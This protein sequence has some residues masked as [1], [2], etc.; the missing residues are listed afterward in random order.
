MT[1]ADPFDPKP[2]DEEDP[3][4]LDD[5]GDDLDDDATA[6]VAVEYN[7]GQVAHTVHRD[8]IQIT[9][10]TRQMQRFHD[11]H[12]LSPEYVR[13]TMAYF[14]ERA[15][16]TVGNQQL[17]RDSAAELFDV[18]SCIVL[19]GAPHSGLRTAGVALLDALSRRP[20]PPLRLREVTGWN[21]A[22]PGSLTEDA[23]PG[24]RCGYLLTIPADQKAP[25]EKLLDG[26]R[27]ELAC[28]ASFL[29]IVASTETFEG[30]AYH[31]PGS[32]LA[33]SPPDGIALLRAEIRRLGI[34][35]RLGGLANHSEIAALARGATPEQV[36]RLARLM[37]EATGEDD[38][39]AKE[40]VAAYKR[41]N[42]ELIRWFIQHRDIR[43]RAFLVATA[44]AEGSHAT[45]VLSCA[46]HL[47]ATLH[48][49]DRIRDG[50]GDAGIQELAQQ[51]G[52]VVGPD[53][54]L[55]FDKPAYGPAVLDYLRQDRSQQFHE[56]FWEWVS[57]LPIALSSSG[58]LPAPLT[59]RVADVILD[60]ILR[61]RD[62]LILRKV[63]VRWS[64]RQDLRPALVAVLSAAAL[65]PEAGSLTRDRLNR[66]AAKSANIGLLC[67]IAEVC[68]DKLADTY[69]A[70]AFVRLSHLA[71]HRSPVVAECV[72]TA[73]ERLW[74]RPRLRH[75]VLDQL[76]QWLASD[77]GP[78]Y[79]TA[80]EVIRCLNATIDGD[81][82]LFVT[83]QLP[84]GQRRLAD[85]VGRIIDRPTA[86]G[87]ELLALWM[88]QSSEDPVLAEY[89]WKVLV[90][91]VAVPAPAPRIA[92]LVQV[93]H[94]WCPSQSE[95]A[96][97]YRRQL[98]DRLVSALCNAD[99][100][101]RRP[102]LTREG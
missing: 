35:E 37:R 65:S 91:T 15:Y 100:M 21:P 5:L 71:D 60:A 73:M 34:G 32:V 28:H 2:L 33:V 39:A 99:P 55:R 43:E 87:S 68:A 59:T 48:G 70:A 97:P 20:G 62:P 56:R 42:A 79:A 25:L 75:R 44:V 66:W 90:D 51:T 11:Y 41:W 38:T 96:M 13:Q 63:A 95:D 82:L 45:F 47:Q 53:C 102:N 88:T 17:N 16:R 57:R 85:V 30:L 86:F 46:D 26:F 89:L 83:S 40:I 74:A 93:A 18:K 12:D 22:R 10:I 9:N 81:T 36:C 76:L 54:T 52:A 14:V 49:Q 80:C 3:L 29:V 94:Q 19:T 31:H 24:Q 98:R 101:V 92:R 77:S 50:L 69:P 6:T 72:A 7:T 4:D 84:S 1:A 61:Y 64:S 58:R 78:A 67:V 23:D 8:M 27:A